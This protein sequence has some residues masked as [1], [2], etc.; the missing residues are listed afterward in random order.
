[1]VF[2]RRGPDGLQVLG[3][4]EDVDVSDQT[5]SFFPE[6]D[7]LKQFPEDR[8]MAEKTGPGRRSLRSGAGS[9]GPAGSHRI[10]ANFR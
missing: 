7:F 3:F 8:R 10:S 9:P 1:M 6:L 4:P 5:V 2:L